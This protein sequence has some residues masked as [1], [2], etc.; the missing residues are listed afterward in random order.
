MVVIGTVDVPI[1]TFLIFLLVSMAVYF[2]VLLYLVLKTNRVEQRTQQI[3]TKLTKQEHIL[4]DEVD[5]LRVIVEPIQY[6]AT[7]YKTFYPH[8]TE[9][10]QKLKTAVEGHAAHPAAPAA[11]PLHAEAPAKA[12]PAAPHSH[13]PA[14]PAAL[15]PE[16][17]AEPK[18]P[19]TMLETLK[20][21]LGS[22]SKHHMPNPFK[23]KEF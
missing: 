1:I 19:L 18:K 7:Y 9:A 16:L 8:S 14:A 13:P 5:A 15:L 21:D 22:T 11:H 10:L 17:H 3:Q 23:K 4:R 6:V 20:S 2:V 12:A